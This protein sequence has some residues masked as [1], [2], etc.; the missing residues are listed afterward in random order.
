M[1]TRAQI[2]SLGRDS[3]EL[4]KLFSQWLLEYKIPLGSS[5]VVTG[6]IAYFCIPYDKSS[7]TLLRESFPHAYPI[8]K[9]LTFWGDYPFICLLPA[10]LGLWTGM[11]GKRSQFLRF[12]LAFLLSGSVAGLT[13]NV[14]RGMLGR[15]RPIAEL[16][17]GIYGPSL[18]YKYHGTPSAHAAVAF[19]C[20]GF[21]ASASPFFALPVS[22]LAIS[23][24]GSRVYLRAHH[25]TDI[26]FGAFIGL[27]IGIGMAASY[28]RLEP[29]TSC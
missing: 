27:W 3:V 19:G 5:L 11:K 29:T 15:P 28:R 10:I 21:V 14:F 25:P 6:V 16:P 4:L 7:I 1:N 8:A 24:G 26:G 18:K 2:A 12:S 20:A 13:S 22:I 23:I 9:A 17:D